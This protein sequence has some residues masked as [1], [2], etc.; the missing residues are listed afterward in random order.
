MH[1]RGD[2]PSNVCPS[3]TF[4]SVQV[5]TGTMSI[6]EV[7]KKPAP[8]KPMKMRWVW[9]S[10]KADVPSR[11][12]TSRTTT[13]GDTNSDKEP[14]ENKRQCFGKPYVAFIL[15]PMKM[16]APNIPDEKVRV[17]VPELN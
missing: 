4:P 5:D 7:H 15:D 3:V 9:V 12:T 16:V 11:P 14:K 10:K 8:N 17:G 2:V 6:P 1:L 13:R